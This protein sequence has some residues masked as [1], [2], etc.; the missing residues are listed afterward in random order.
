MRP[1][2]DQLLLDA[3]EL[4]KAAALATRV[5]TSIHGPGW[6]RGAAQAALYELAAEA[7]AKAGR[8]L[9]QKR[10]QELRNS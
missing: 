9:T 3:I 8:F 1:D 2:A 10:I 7:E 5:H 4:R 6:N